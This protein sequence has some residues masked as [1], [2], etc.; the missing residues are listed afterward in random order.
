[1]EVLKGGVFVICLEAGTR[2]FEG[3]QEG[4]DSLIWCTT[5]LCRDDLSVVLN[6]WAGIL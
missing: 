4:P 1:M 2:N 3:G 6:L 5:Y